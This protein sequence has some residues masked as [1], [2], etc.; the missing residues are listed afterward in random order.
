MSDTAEHIDRLLEPILASLGLTLWDLE[1]KKEGPR[2]LLRIYIDRESTGVTLGDCE[3][4]SRDLGTTL[5]VNE[6][7]PHAYTLEV[8]SPGLDRS[9]TR[10]EHYQRSIG[11]QV[12]I[13]TYQ[14]VDD[15][16]VFFGTLTGIEE[17]TIIIETEKG[18]ALSFPLEN[19]AKANLLVVI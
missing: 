1:F 15:E 13:K 9:L 19:I 2:W 6:I 4:V 17:G 16:K 7:M 8:S 5:D 12:R 11:M 18:A 3:A 14:A 10:P